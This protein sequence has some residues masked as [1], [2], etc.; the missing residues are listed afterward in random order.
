MCQLY[1]FQVEWLRV[2]LLQKRRCKINWINHGSVETDVSGRLV[3][4]FRTFSTARGFWLIF[5]VNYCRVV[6]VR[7]VVCH[8][9]L[10]CCSASAARGCR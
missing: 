10:E 3:L 7:V 9:L 4:L 8:A 5:V 2:K 6:E 1:H